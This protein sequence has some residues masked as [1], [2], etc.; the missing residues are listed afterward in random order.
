MRLIHLSELA[1]EIAHA[2]DIVQ[3]LQTLLGL[4]PDSLESR[5]LLRTLEIDLWDEA[6]ESRN[7]MKRIQTQ[8]LVISAS[9]TVS[10]AEKA[11][12]DSQYG[13]AM[14][15]A[16]E[17]L[18]SFPTHERANLVL[19]E[20]AKA[21]EMPTT[22]SFAYEMVCYGKPDDPRCL[23]LLAEAQVT[24]GDIHGAREIYERILEIAPDDQ[25]AIQSLTQIQ[26][27]PHTAVPHSQPEFHPE[28][29]AQ[30][31]RAFPFEQ[32]EAQLHD[33]DQQIHELRGDVEM[34]SSQQPDLV[35]LQQHRAQVNLEY[36]Y[37]RV[38]QNPDDLTL[39]YE[40]AH[41]YFE[42]SLFDEA[43]SLFTSTLENGELRLASFK[44]LCQCLGGQLAREEAL[45]YQ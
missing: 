9:R 38:A 12:K 1:G 24:E 11:I 14:S 33:L 18:A 22:V 45:A 29:D 2:D 21:M 3:F 37:Y 32:V 16:E 40:L 17:V 41:A 28:V 25:D 34:D 42:S 43:K 36:R 13:Q 4:R 8:A 6:R 44:G 39:R 30:T 5:R 35:D 23:H 7:P 26:H 15:L 19:A 10:Q 20:C 31:L 27:Q